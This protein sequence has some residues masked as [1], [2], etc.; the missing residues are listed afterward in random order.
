MSRL[1]APRDRLWRDAAGAFAGLI[2]GT[3]LR[4]ATLILHSARWA[5]RERDAGGTVSDIRDI[6]ILSGEPASIETYNALL[7]RQEAA[8]TALMP[9]MA[10]IDAEAFRIADPGHQW[11]LSPFHYVPEYYDAVRSQLSDMGL[12]GAFSDPRA[13]PSAQAA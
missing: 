13:A 12:S 4:R 5:T 10:R 9:P 6:E 2:R 1:S 11:G 8:F 3:E 7:M